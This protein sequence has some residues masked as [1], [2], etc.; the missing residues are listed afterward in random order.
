MKL[1]A[2]LGAILLGAPPANAE[3]PDV[4]LIYL[5][6]LGYGD[7]GCY[8]SKLNDT[9]YTD[10]LAAGGMRFTDY[11]QLGLTENTLVIF[12]S[13]NGIRARGEGGSNAPL[14][15]TKGQTWE[16]R[17]RVPCIAS[18]PATIPPGSLSSHLQPDSSVPPRPAPSL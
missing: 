8:G 15:G 2:I 7:L 4:I 13:D 10:R 9:P 17:M 5:D 12:T 3:P 14:R 1:A 11:Y 6:D 16:G 18:W